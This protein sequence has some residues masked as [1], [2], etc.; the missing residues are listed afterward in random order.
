MR[1]PDDREVSSGGE[2]LREMLAGQREWRAKCGNNGNSYIILALDIET[3]GHHHKGAVEKF[4]IPFWEETRRLK[5]ECEI[6]PLRYIF[7]EFSKIVLG[8]DDIYPGS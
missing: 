1:Y 8:R 6:V 3:F 2:F 4:L 7:E 5:N